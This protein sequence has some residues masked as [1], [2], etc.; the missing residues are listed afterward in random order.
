MIFFWKK[1]I[2]LESS[3]SQLINFYEIS[4]RAIKNYFRCE[5]PSSWLLNKCKSDNFLM[6]KQRNRIILDRLS[7]K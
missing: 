6:K 2:I 4:N 5:E 3:S 7:V 1:Q